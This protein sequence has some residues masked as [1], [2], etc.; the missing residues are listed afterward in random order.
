M[1]EYIE[2][3]LMK[4]RVCF[5]R[6]AT[7]QWFVIAV[8]GLLVCTEHSGVTS[9]VRSLGINPMFYPSLLH[10]FHASSWTLEGIQKIWNG[11]VANS[12]LM[13][14]VEDMPVLVGDGTK[15]SKEGRKMPGV[16]RLHQE[17]GNSAKPEY[18]HGHM[19][20][21]IG[22]LIGNG[23]KIFCTLLSMRIHDGNEV[24]G[25][26]EDDKYADESHVVRM[27]REAFAIALLIGPPCLL[28]L[29]SYFLSAPALELL[30]QLESEYG[31]KML[32]LVTKAKT[33]ATAWE[34]PTPKKGRGAPRK[35]GAKVKLWQLFSSEAAAFTK[36]KV[37]LYGKVEEIEYLVKDLL[38]SEGLYFE[39][40]FVFVKWGKTETLLACTNLLLTPERIIELYGLR[41][42]IECSF[43]AFK[44]AVA[45]FAYRFW[46]SGMP[47]LNPFAK[48]DDM[49][50]VVEAVA[51]K[52]IQTRIVN[53]F[54]ATERFVMIACI[55]LGLLQMTALRFGKEIYD[56]AFLWMRTKSNDTPSEATTADFMR[57]TIFHGF[58]FSPNLSISRIIQ[59]RMLGPSAS[60]D[61]PAA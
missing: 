35:R 48:N 23:S 10:F 21:G 56:S 41:F 61:V 29:D 9:I 50:A 2:E 24:F 59:S 58:Y 60:F 57:K 30:K 49:R 16:K 44:Q 26:W 11:I 7:F 4:F 27:V 38:W 6:T 15:V 34:K 39:L 25:K 45:G 53:A 28:L 12:G 32:T 22:T 31:R 52:A 46:T 36:T 13:Y 33:S 1:W 18:I 14:R 54:K 3:R 51:D 5:S 17:S 8:I 20:G 42:K 37:T 19:F 47:K 55:V 43:R 40:R